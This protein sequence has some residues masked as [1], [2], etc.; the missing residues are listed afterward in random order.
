M[1]AILGRST[2]QIDIAA[3][4][5][6]AAWAG[7]AETPEAAALDASVGSSV[8]SF[9]L[10]DGDGIESSEQQD[11][12]QWG[13]MPVNS[14]E[15][16]L[17]PSFRLMPTDGGPVQMDGSYMMPQRGE[18]GAKEGGR[19]DSNSWFDAGLARLGLR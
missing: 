18:D 10:I 16:E 7:V 15:S 12:G 1:T 8:G 3:S 6:A 17:D 11:G 14:S 19:R 4:C 9:V 13:D 2:S 5:I